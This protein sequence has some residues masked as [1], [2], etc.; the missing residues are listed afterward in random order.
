MD[1]REGFDLVVMN[2]PWEAVKPEDDD[3]FSG[4]LPKF[5]RLKSKQEKE[6]EK[7]KLLK[8]KAI[9]AEFQDYVERIEDKVEFYKLSEQYVKRGG[10]DTDLWKLFLERSFSLLASEGTLSL[11]LPSGIV[12]NEGAKELRKELLE[13]KIQCLYEFENKNGIFA[14]VH[15]SYKF[16]LV[17]CTNTPSTAEFPAAFY[18]H[19]LESLEG[20]TEQTKFFQMPFSLIN[21]VSPGSLVIPEPRIKTDVQLLTKLYSLHPKLSENRNWSAALVVEL[22]RTGDSDIFN[23]NGK[24]W[25]LIEGKYFH[26]F[27]PDFERPQFAVDSKLGLARTSKRREYG[28]FNKELHNL[29]RLVMRAIGS[30]TNVR[31]AI[32]CIM[33]PHTFNDHNVTVILPTIKNQIAANTSYYELI[34]YL[35]AIFNSYSFDYLIR[36]RVAIYIGFFHINNTPIPTAFKGNIPDQIISIASRLSSPDKRFQDFGDRMK[37]QCRL[38]SMKERIE[39][40][41]KLDALVAHHYGLTHDEYQYIIN[42]FEGFEEDEN[43]VN[44]TEIHWDDRLIRKFNGE[45]RKRV[46]KYYDEIAAEMKENVN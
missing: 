27:I 30:S 15:R 23:Q 32:A 14:D 31:S 10:G 22:H 28:S 43:I 5:R 26:Q 36:L 11:V 40:T 18:L 20:K 25:P 46:L 16:A 38:P 33:P 17:V 3:F 12:T 4:Y 8:E 21:S 9:A 24:G 41:A 19:D 34:S 44:L 7:Q 29:P 2:P 37:I 39:L 13:R 6:K 35:G 1:E 45:V 42:T